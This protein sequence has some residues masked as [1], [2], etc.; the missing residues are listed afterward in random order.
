[1]HITLK[2]QNDGVI[3][4]TCPEN[5]VIIGR[6]SKCHIR[7]PMEGMSREHVQI[8]VE[9]RNIFV[10]DLNSTNGVFIDGKKIGPE[11]KVRFQTGQTLSFGP[12]DGVEIDLNRK[13]PKT[14]SEK[15]SFLSEGDSGDLTKTRVIPN[16]R[17]TQK[18]QKDKEKFKS[19]VINVMTVLILVGVAHWY[20]NGEDEGESEDV[21]VIQE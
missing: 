10:T 16:L 6:S 15:A 11:K 20:L 4:R 9:N 21:E 5:E 13:V 3:E 1:M 7:V 18:N 12:V 8:S 2:L 14:I 19:F 17:Q